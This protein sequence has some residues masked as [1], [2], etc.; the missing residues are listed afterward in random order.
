MAVET[1]SNLITCA[2][3]GGL[4]HRLLFRRACEEQAKASESSNQFNLE[5]TV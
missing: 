4:A 1:E 5:L 3:L 2:S